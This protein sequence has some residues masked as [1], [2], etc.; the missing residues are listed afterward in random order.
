MSQT[1][2]CCLWGD[3]DPGHLRISCYR[4][5]A[6]LLLALASSDLKLPRS[7]WDTFC[8]TP[9]LTTDAQHGESQRLGSTEVNY[10]LSFHQL[11]AELAKLKAVVRESPSQIKYACFSFLS[12][13]CFLC[14]SFRHVS[15]CLF[16]LDSFMV[17]ILQIKRAISLCR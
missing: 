8:Q 4:S 5:V 10:S 14:T 17:L 2:C 13:L 15:L 3:R 9:H 16:A 1:Q 7:C 12:M 6:L 11:H